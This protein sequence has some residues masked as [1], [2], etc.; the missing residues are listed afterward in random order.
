MA[1]TVCPAVAAAL[2]AEDTDFEDAAEEEL[3]SVS[4]AG[5][6]SKAVAKEL[7]FEGE[8]N[9]IIAM[10]ATASNTEYQEKKIIEGRRI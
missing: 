9:E 5:L 2:K 4:V 8:M 7:K 3:F 1:D 10:I 6:A